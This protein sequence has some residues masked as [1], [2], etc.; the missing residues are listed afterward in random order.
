M[1]AT[2]IEWAD[3]VWNPVTGC[4][5]VSAGCKHCYAETIAHRFWKGRDFGDVQCHEDRLD[6]PRRWRKPSRVFVNSMSDLF[7]EA[8]PFEFIG[9]VFNK[10]LQANYEGRGHSFLVLTKRPA[11]MVEWFQTI[12]N[13]KQCLY[14]FPVGESP[15]DGLPPHIAVGVSVEDQRTADERI[16]LLAQCPAAVRFLSVEPLLGPVQLDL[17]DIHWVIVGGESGPKARPCNAIWVRSVLDQCRA[18][19]V[20]CFVK[21]LGS[22][23]IDYEGCPIKPGDRKGG[24]PAEWPEDLRVREYP[25]VAQ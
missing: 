21:Q 23:A 18:S 1:S 2:E 8:V 15:F 4:T 25:K 5:K 19:G 22:G 3:R 17:T 16:P 11:R 10:M 20:P 6:E 14:G 9:R 7:H 24:D 12:T 13:W